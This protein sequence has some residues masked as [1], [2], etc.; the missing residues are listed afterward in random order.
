MRRPANLPRRVLSSRTDSGNDKSI[1]RRVMQMRVCEQ[2][3]PG[4]RALSDQR[5]NDAGWLNQ[6][7]SRDAP[8]ATRR[9][10]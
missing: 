3:G 9:R 4:N 10:H 7:N 6:I 5:S 2:R 1:G 8:A